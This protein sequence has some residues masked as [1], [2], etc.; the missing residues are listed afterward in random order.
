[1]YTEL[2]LTAMLSADTPTDVI[3][4]IK[5]M[6]GQSNDPIRKPD[7]ALFQIPGWD[8]MLQS[9]SAL[10]AGITYSRIEQRNASGRY[11]LS[12]HC[13]FRTEEKLPAFLEWIWQYI[14]SAPGRFIGYHRREGE[15]DPTLIYV[16]KP[17]MLEPSEALVEVDM[18]GYE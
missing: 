17:E 12:V 9:D 4:T 14:D 1:M 15:A 2:H 11:A 6:T 8:S 10:F 16:P 3:D 13:N 5:R 7:H 18:A